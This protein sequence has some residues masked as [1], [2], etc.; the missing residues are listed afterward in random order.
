MP[1]D[2]RKTR[3][4]MK[5]MISSVEVSVILANMRSAGPPKTPWPRPAMFSERWAVSSRPGRG[6][7]FLGHPGVYSY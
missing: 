1:F 5:E 3:A 4:E 2:P 6:R 7:G